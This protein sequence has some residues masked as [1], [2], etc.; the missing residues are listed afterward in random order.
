MGLLGSAE[1][2][3]SHDPPSVASTACGHEA[4]LERLPVSA[5]VLAC[6]VQRKGKD[7]QVKWREDFD[8]VDECFKFRLSGISAVAP[9]I[10]P[11]LRE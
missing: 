6:I 2:P 7:V 4:P 3:E 8:A 10:Q 11:E 9:V 1:R 5:P